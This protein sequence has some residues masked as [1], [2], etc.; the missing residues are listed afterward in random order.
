MLNE[1]LSL[2]CVSS[3]IYIYAE[4]IDKINKN[5]VCEIELDQ[6]LNRNKDIV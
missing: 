6:T 5:V 4:N 1:T 3:L 2:L